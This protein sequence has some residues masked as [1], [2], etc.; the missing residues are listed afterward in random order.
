[1]KIIL[2]LA[3]LLLGFSLNAQLIFK[4]G[5]ETLK[6][7]TIRARHG[8]VA[9][10]DSTGKKIAYYRISG[11]TL[12]LRDTGGEKA[13]ASMSAGAFTASNGDTTVGND[14]QLG[15]MLSRTTSIKM[16]DHPFTLNNMEATYPANY[17]FGTSYFS[18]YNYRTTSK[19]S[20]LLSTYSGSQQ[21][22]VLEADDYTN[23]KTNSTQLKVNPY[24][25]RFTINATNALYNKG[26]DADSLGFRLT[27]LADT[28]Y[29]ADG[30]F[31]S[32]RQMKNEM[33]ANSGGVTLTLLNNKAKWKDS[34]DIFLGSDPPFG[35]AYSGN[36]NYLIGRSI[37][38]GGT[39]YTAQYNTAIGFEAM[40]KCEDNSGCIAIGYRALK[41]TTAS[42]GSI[43]IGH[44][45]MA[46]YNA[47][48]ENIAIGAA[49]LANCQGSY[50]N[51]AIG[52]QS[53][54]ATTTGVLNTAFG[55]ES[56]IANT[57]GNYNVAIGHYALIS[58][59]INDSSI[60][61]GFLAGNGKNVDN[62]LYIGHSGDSTDCTIWSN[63]R[64][65]YK[66]VIINNQ[67]GIHKYP[68]CALDVNGQIKSTQISAALTDGTPTDS[69]LDAATGSTPSGVGAGW[70]CFIKDSNGSGLV[71][72]IYSDGTDWYYQAMTKAL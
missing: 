41:N 30:T 59:T 24:Y 4:G 32:F 16:N 70:Q 53:A 68:T 26:Y 14:I 47:G 1:M 19:I 57:S 12:Y 39:L 28:A 25:L 33:L 60:A 64:P 31:V 23:S 55:D 15:S 44:G 29:K 56:L 6:I 36:D 2:V 46:N 21:N 8:R 20:S 54:V 11:D 35:A 69:E 45:A 34:T 52:Y 7:D 62:R 49:S 13:L 27:N 10:T 42:Q 58:N 3:G 50:G 72:R 22:L 18:F 67:L 38:T 5:K 61:V 71:Y 37:F 51:T 43:A 63:M 66:K 9:I 17:V 40:N 65:N 48:Y